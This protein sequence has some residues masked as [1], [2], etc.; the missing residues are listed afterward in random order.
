[1]CDIRSDLL[2]KAE[3]AG[4]GQKA[5]GGGEDQPAGNQRDSDATEILRE[6]ASAAAAY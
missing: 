5:G 3:E 6:I 2:P 1:M 4:G